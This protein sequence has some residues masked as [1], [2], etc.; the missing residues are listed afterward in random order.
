[1]ETAMSYRHLTLSE[2]ETIANLLFAGHGPTVISR[3]LG[4]SPSTISR[5][6][7]RNSVNGRYRPSV[8]HQRCL[9]RRSG[10]PLQRKISHPPLRS[11]V[12]RLLSCCWSPDQVSGRL[13]RVHPED[14]RMHVSHQ[15]IYRWLWSNS[16]IAEE[17]AQDLRHGRYRRRKRSPRPVIRNRVSIHQRP[18]VI[19][20][21][22]R[23]GDWEGD[24]IVGRAHSGYVATF[25]DRR[26]GYLVASRMRDKRSVSLNRAAERAFR[27]VPKEARHSI[28]VDNGTEF[29]K[30]KSLAR[31]LKINIYFADAYCS[32]QRGT[33][34]N[35]NGLLR[36]FLPKNQE[37]FD[38][39][40]TVL[41]FHVS[42]LNNRPR[43]RL[44]YLTPAEVF[45]QQLKRQQRCT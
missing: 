5:E 25:V 43:K 8:A 45:H 36:Q 30:H 29:A 41:E 31:R 9:S 26:S 23:V 14:R 7:G 3:A 4:R 37:L 21:R 33:N 39:P 38:L 44:G 22:H 10:R 19:E 28:T 11:E 27:S 2:R 20:A 16:A 32:W 34:E 17:F 13:K 42:R 15:T 18:S 12:Q 6:I 35:T 24:T 40:P 1:M